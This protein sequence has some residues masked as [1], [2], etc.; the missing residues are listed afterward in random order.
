MPTVADVNESANR[1]SQEQI[2]DAVTATLVGWGR[3]LDMFQ[4]FWWMDWRTMMDDVVE[5]S[6]TGEAV[7][8]EEDEREPSDR[9]VDEDPSP[10]DEILSLRNESLNPRRAGVWL[11]A[12]NR[13]LGGKRPIGLIA[14]G[15]LERVR[16]SAELIKLG[17][18]V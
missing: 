5:A 16:R 8:Y 12:K 9:R 13:S 4:K 7:V 18:G 14:S 15:E 2:E 1:P 6:R 17:A 10:V 11:L 3:E